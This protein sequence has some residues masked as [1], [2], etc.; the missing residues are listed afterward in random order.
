MFTLVK[1]FKC[2]VCVQA[3]HPCKPH[4]PAEERNLAPLELIYSDLC[5]MNGALKKLERNIS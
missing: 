1:D 5:E 4:K 3:K 2:H